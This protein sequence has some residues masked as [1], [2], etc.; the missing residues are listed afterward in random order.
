MGYADGAAA[1]PVVDETTGCDPF[2]GLMC[3]FAYFR[4]GIAGS[5][6]TPSV[7]SLSPCQLAWQSLGHRHSPWI[8]WWKTTIVNVPQLP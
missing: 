7:S 2:M 5:P 1:I 8:D 6:V 3:F 4:N